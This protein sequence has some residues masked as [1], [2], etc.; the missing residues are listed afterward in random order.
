VEEALGK[1]SVERPIADSTIVLHLKY[2]LRMR[3][4]WNWLRIMSS[5]LPS[6][7]GVEL[8]FFGMA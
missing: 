1:W 7:I 4:K 5:V 3:R 6:A 8:L 2:V